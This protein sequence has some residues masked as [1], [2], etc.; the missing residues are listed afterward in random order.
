MVAAREDNPIGWRNAAIVSLLFD[1]GLRSGE[2]CR[3]GVCEVDLSE[4]EL[5]VLIKGGNTMPGWFGAATTARLKR[6]LSVRSAWPGI[7]TVFVGIG[8]TTPVRQ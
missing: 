1:S 8:G 3:L 2:L 4:R 6:W 7:E 5:K